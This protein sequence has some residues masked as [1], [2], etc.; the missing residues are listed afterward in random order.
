[1]KYWYNKHISSCG[2]I[3]KDKK[4]SMK[5]IN[6]HEYEKEF[7]NRY[8]TNIIV[9]YESCADCIIDEKNDI[10]LKIQSSLGIKNSYSVSLKSGSNIH[11]VL[12]KIDELSID[13]NLQWLS[14]KNNC[15]YIF[16][17]YL[18][19]Y[20]SNT[21]CSLLVYRDI[22]KWI[23]FSMND[24]IE[25][26]VKNIKWRQLS[27]GRIKGDFD[28][29]SRKGFS[30]YITYEYRKTHKQYFLGCNGNK[31]KLFIYLLMNNINYFI[32]SI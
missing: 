17:K 26:I 15:R 27:S 19:K 11:F 8:C 13:N 6:G 31:G 5:K 14:K 12:G 4:M 9:T 7:M 3:I 32:E 30:Q 1:M 16:K 22:N 25:F 2:N 10:C 29:Y 28:D 20:Y 21:P 18:Q 23:F 24:I